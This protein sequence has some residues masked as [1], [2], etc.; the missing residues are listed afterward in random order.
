M[1]CATNHH[2]RGLSH[3]AT[4]GQYRDNITAL[5]TQMAALVMLDEHNADLRKLVV[6]DGFRRAI[7]TK[8]SSALLRGG[9]GVAISQSLRGS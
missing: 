4:S 6:P 2:S 5:T 7:A 8:E 1:E 9:Q 3:D